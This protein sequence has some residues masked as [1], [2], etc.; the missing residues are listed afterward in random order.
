MIY[1]SWSP[2]I[3]EICMIYRSPL[4]TSDLDDLERDLD[5]IDRNMYD[6]LDRNLYDDLD[7]DLYDMW[8]VHAPLVNRSGC[9]LAGLRGS[10]VATTAVR[11]QSMP[12]N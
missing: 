2:T 3:G 6:D 4:Q 5:Y 9:S 7:C 10:F 11:W 12:T 8:T 1:R